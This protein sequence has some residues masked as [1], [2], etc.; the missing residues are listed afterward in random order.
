MRFSVLDFV[1]SIPEDLPKW[2]EANTCKVCS[3]SFR[4]WLNWRHHCRNCGGS[5][6]ERHSNKRVNKMAGG[7]KLPMGERVRSTIDCVK[8]RVCVNCYMIIENV[9]S[10][11]GR[12]GE[13]EVPGL[14]LE[15]VWG[16]VNW[17]EEE[18]GEQEILK[19]T[20]DGDASVLYGDCDDDNSHIDD[21]DAHISAILNSTEN[22]DD[23]DLDD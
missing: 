15:G 11:G 10:E 13:R 2:Q 21:I 22:L 9:D 5:F 1:E 6:C 16:L 7:R 23:V 18:E 3:W 20:F 19:S 12:M 8:S 14:P 4:W 17:G